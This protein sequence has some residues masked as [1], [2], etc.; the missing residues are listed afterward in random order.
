MY[1]MSDE[2]IKKDIVDIVDNEA[3]IKF[4]QL[5]PKKYK[6]KNGRFGDKEVYGFIA[7]EVESI[8][9]NSCNNLEDY[10]PNIQLSA[11]IT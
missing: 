11:N 10:V 8:I 3:L 9:P 7:Q 4:R 5:K 6:Y 1:I 2:R